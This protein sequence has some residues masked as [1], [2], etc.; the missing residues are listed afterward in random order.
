MRLFSLSALLAAAGCEGDFD[1]A[2]RVASFNDAGRVHVSLFPLQD[3]RN[4]RTMVLD[5]DGKKQ[6]QLAQGLK[7]KFTLTADKAVEQAIPTTTFSETMILTALLA[8]LGVSPATTNI[9]GEAADA[10]EPPD[11]KVAPP[12]ID[13]K[14]K[15]QFHTTP[16]KLPLPV[17]PLYK[18]AV[19]AALYQQTRLTD[20]AIESVLRAKGHQALLAPLNI[21]VVPFAHRQPYDVYLSVNFTVTAKGSG[22]TPL[23]V[24]VLPLL[25]SDNVEGVQTART[26]ELLIQAQLALK[27][28][29]AGTG[30]L[31]D[32]G[33]TRQKVQSA[34]GTDLNSLLTVGRVSNSVLSVRIGAQRSASSTYATVARNTTVWTLLLVS[35]TSADGARLVTN[36]PTGLWDI[37]AISHATLRDAE[38]GKALPYNPAKGEDEAFRA[39]V[40]RLA[41][42]D[43]CR[44]TL[45]ADDRSE[46][47]QQRLRGI[48]GK[49]VRQPRDERGMKSLLPRACQDDNE[50]FLRSTLPTALL[51][52]LGTSDYSTV[53]QYFW[54]TEPPRMR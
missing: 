46:T 15:P 6:I 30:F 37:N 23:H 39:I 31:F 16:D 4:P 34:L 18:Y 48:R 26:V 44:R 20:A 32:G 5:S 51:E 17:D 41:Q 52:T 7:P 21:D 3:F 33:L 50:R 25:V 29:S 40:D 14:N 54:W 28:M 43:A 35:E 45:L 9:K 53:T 24:T 27:A 13:P 36:P 10:P 11:P 12:T 42:S 1:N 47:W 2:R 38:N 22:S 19:A 8:K 49:I